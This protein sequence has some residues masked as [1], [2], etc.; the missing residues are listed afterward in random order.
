[1]CNNNFVS[2]L[3]IIFIYNFFFFFFFE[4]KNMICK[5]I[6]IY[7]FYST[8]TYIYIPIAAAA[9]IIWKLFIYAFVPLNNILSVYIHALKKKKKKICRFPE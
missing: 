3:S 2:H 9:E 4:K 8:Y 7:W 1:M 5:I 6:K